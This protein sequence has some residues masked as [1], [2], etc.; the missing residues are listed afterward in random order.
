MRMARSLVECVENITAQ[1]EPH[2]ATEKSKPDKSRQLGGIDYVDPGDMEIKDTMTN[3]RKKM[4]VQ[5][6]SAM[7]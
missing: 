4:K 2:A 1:E 3:S 5:M 6:E 7:P